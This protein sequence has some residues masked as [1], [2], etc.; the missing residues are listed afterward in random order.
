MK[1]TQTMKKTSVFPFS[2]DVIWGRLRHLNTL[3]HIAKPFASFIPLD[4]T[5]NPLWQEGET[6]R[7]RLRLFGFLSLGVHTI[8]VLRLDSSTYEIETHEHNAFVPVWNHRITLEP[9]DNGHTRY[10]D[11]VELFSPYATGV[12]KIWAQ[13]F[14]AHR[15]RQWVTL[16]QAD[17]KKSEEHT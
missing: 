17:A 15:Q 16:L 2:A 11:E 8:R 4:S 9:L 3:Q 14:Y 1:K 5:T 13:A 7:L 10:T 6:L 12:V